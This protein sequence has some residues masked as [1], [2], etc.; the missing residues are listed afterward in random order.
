MTPLVTTD[1]GCSASVSGAITDLTR[2]TAIS[3]ITRVIAV[4]MIILTKA[5]VPE[6]TRSKKEDASS[7]PLRTALKDETVP[8]SDG[9]PGWSMVGNFPPML[10]PKL[11]RKLTEHSL[12]TFFTMFATAESSADTI[13]STFSSFLNRLT[14]NCYIMQCSMH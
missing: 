7:F 11:V 12:I 10:I 6:K 14:I 2:F 5:C 13:Q 9:E 8:E 1:T 3:R 4:A